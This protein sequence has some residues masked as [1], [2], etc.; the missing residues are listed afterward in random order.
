MARMLRVVAVGLAA[1]AVVGVVCGGLAR[2][3]MRLV[4]VFA[5]EEGSFSLAGTAAIMV[6]FAVFALPG[7]V[8]AAAWRGRGRS[9]LLVLAGM[10]LCVP[11]TGTARSDLETT[12]LLGFDVVLVGGAVL[13]VYLAALALPV[14]GLR[15]VDLLRRRSA[16]SELGLA[17]RGQVG[18]PLGLDALGG[19]GVPVHDHGHGHHVGAGLA[20]GGDRGERRP[21]RRA[22]VLDDQHPAALDR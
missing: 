20:Q 21:A 16:Q 9:T 14:V 13:G 18:Q 6:V 1:A 8:L 3:F 22:G 11:I 17:D 4:V 2:L 10:A 12:L 19:T 7:A 15:A 5:G